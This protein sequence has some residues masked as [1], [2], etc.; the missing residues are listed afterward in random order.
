[1]T[2]YDVAIVGGGAMGSAAAYYL[3]ALQ[4]DI[5]IAVFE[6][7]PTYEYC[8]T[9]RSDGNLRIQ[10]NLEE[11]IRMSQFTMELLETFAD[12]MEVDGWRPDPAARRQG[13]LF[14]VE[15]SDRQVAEAGMATQRGLGCE[16]EWLDAA[17]IA[18]RFPSYRTE[19]VVGGVLGRND[20][21]IDPHAV[22]HGFRRNAIK[23]GVDYVGHEVAAIEARADRVSGIRLATGD[24]VAAA[25]VVLCAGGWSTALARTIGIELP[26]EP[27]MRT[28]FVVDTEID[29]AG[30]PS[31]FLPGGAYVLPEG[32][33]SF[34]MAWSQPT[35]PIGFDFRFSR[36]GFE[37]EVWPQIIE[38]LPEFDRLAVTGGWTGIYALNN[39]DGNA[40]LGPWP[41]LDGLLMA[42]GFSGHGFQHSPAMG[43]YIAELIAGREPTLDLSRLG[44]QRILS[45]EPLFEHEGR[46]I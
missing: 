18:E 17:A 21:S 6:K 45:G 1:M 13:N 43:R 42:T 14:L 10:F 11:N 24:I 35:D 26:V 8:S 16:I 19:G 41:E 25:N 38:T 5:S 39:L 15:E 37:E 23:L 22:M 12:D 3:R 28:V 27:I 9:L 34:S 30:L 46:I 31:I 7:D 2:S 20:G 44:P 29:T 32:H 36:S 4:P 40:I 33:R